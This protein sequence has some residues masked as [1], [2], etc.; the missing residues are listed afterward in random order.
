M[1]GVWKAH[2]EWIDENGLESDDGYA[3]PNGTIGASQIPA[4]EISHSRNPIK[5]IPRNRRIE[6]MVVGWSS[7][8][9]IM[10]VY[11]RG[12]GMDKETAE[13]KAGRVEVVT[14]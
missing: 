9:W 11:P 14:M 6:K 8:I 7:T 5:A 10:N 4:G 13:R 12:F 2:V 3:E 1:A